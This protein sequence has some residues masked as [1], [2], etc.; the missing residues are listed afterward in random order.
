MNK[1]YHKQQISQILEKFIN[2]TLMDI[3]RS[4]DLYQENIQKVNIGNTFLCHSQYLP[5]SLTS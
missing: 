5:H 4:K 2:K 3:F 1:S